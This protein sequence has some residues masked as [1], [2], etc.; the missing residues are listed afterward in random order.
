M[1]LIHTPLTAPRQ[2]VGTVD[3]THESRR[4]TARCLEQ[5]QGHQRSSTAEIV[6]MDTPARMPRADFIVTVASTCAGVAVVLLL[7][8]E[9]VA[10]W[11]FA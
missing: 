1:N 4:P 6:P 11:L 8:A 9:R 2:F 5:L 3:A 10:P 7:I